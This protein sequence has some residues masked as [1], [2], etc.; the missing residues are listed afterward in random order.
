MS[1]NQRFRPRAHAAAVSILAFCV[2][3]AAQ[4]AEPG[5][6]EKLAQFS[7]PG[8]NLAITKT[9]HLAARPAEHPPGRPGF[10]GQLPAR[11]RVEGVIDQ[12]VGVA[13]VAYGIHFALALP[14]EWNGRFLFQG[15]GGLNGS[16]QPPLGAAAAGDT[17]A[18]AHG[19]AVVSNDTGHQGAVFDASFYADQEA[20]LNFLY[21]AN[22]KVAPVAKA[23]VDAY[24]R[25]PAE[26][27]YFVGCSTGGREAM[28]MSQRYPGLFDG[29]VAG[30]PAMRTGYSN[31]GMRS[32]S[33]ALATAARRDG[34]GKVI[35]GSALSAGDKELV[36]HGA[37]A[38]CDAKDGLADGLIE[39]PIGCDFDPAVLTCSG[40]KTDQCL[41]STQVAAVKKAMA[42]PKSVTGRQVYPGYLYDTG[43]GTTAR[44]SIPGVLNGAA[45]PVGPNPPPAEQ[46]V[47]AEAAAAAV[48]PSSFGDT[49]Q[50]TNLSTFRA[51]G[52][53]LLF[54]HGVSDPWFSALDTVRYYRALANANGGLDETRTWSRLFLVP[55]MG[56]C[57]GG[58]ATLDR[59][60]MLSAIVD[61]VEKGRAPASV[62][63][64]GASF[65]GR[66]RP[67]CPYPQHAQYS[68]KG[69]SEQAGN[70]ACR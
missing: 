15:G 20:M 46:D 69:D 54:Y 64:T 5:A 51:H 37:L 13:G 70:F 66:S 8:V 40:P 10:A 38:A 22:G 29:I 62:T 61:W 35:P 36:V 45:S 68:G 32:V 52:G 11:C 19:F 57:A 17:P 60:D 48:A 33:V 39:D 18:L 16:V 43:I 2:G 12:R 4:G 6:C 7:L 34:E 41:S 28:M 23:L 58:E 14:D 24:Y 3:V 47:D 55:G 63:A 21:A 26:R 56:H 50:W 59:F 65:P 44:G 27:S 49:A 42:G 67:L 53:K 30:A 1:V 9:E 31:L 25:R